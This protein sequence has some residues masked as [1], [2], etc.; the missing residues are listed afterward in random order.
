MP[1]VSPDIPRVSVVMIFLDAREF[2]AAAIDSVLAQTIADWELILVDDGS[3]DGSS[4]MARRYAADHPRRIRYLEH[5]GHANRGTGISRNTGI[6]AARA[7]YVAFLDADDEYLPA[8]LERHL[9]AFAAHPELGMVI[10]NSLFWHSWHGAQQ[11]QDEEIGHW[12]SNVPLPPPE[13][14]AM[15]LC[16]RKL[17]MPSPCGITFR[18]DVALAAGGIPPQFTDQYEDQVLICQLMLVAPVLALDEC[19]ARYR[20]HERSLTARARSSG[21]YRPGR[22]HQARFVF[23]SWLQDAVHRRGGVP[24]PRLER[25]LRRQLWP[26]RH[27]RLNAV[28][29]WLRDGLRRGRLALR[30]VRGT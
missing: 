4:E 13:L 5:A 28:Y 25:G 16:T 9:Q 10:S 19:L 14:L 6:A 8:R 11:D 1:P 2:I 30:G 24:H 22:V 18:R 20:Q 15:I 29:E 12:P 7:G 26:W 23:L 3:T 17:P 21:A 27:P